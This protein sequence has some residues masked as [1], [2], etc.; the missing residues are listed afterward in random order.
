MIILKSAWRVVKE[1]GHI[2]L[3]GAP[4]GFDRR[5]VT[6]VLMQEVKGITSV[7]HIHAWS[8]TQERPMV[9]LEIEVGADK[10]AK[11]AKARVKEIL[12]DQFN[13][14]HSTVE[15]I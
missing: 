9:T 5:K 10:N 8:V 14:E 2:L 13:I 6:E 1:S 15:L 12:R 11:A 4:K 3:E 7:N